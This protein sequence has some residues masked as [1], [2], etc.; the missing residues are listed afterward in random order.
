MSL[1]GNRDIDIE[2]VLKVEDISNIRLVN[3]YFKCICESDALWYRKI[4]DK[5]NLVKRD[6][7]SKKGDLIDIEITGERIR[8]MQKFLGL[9]NLKGLDNI[10]NKLPK[11]AIYL[12]Y[13][14]FDEHSENFEEIYNLKNMKLPKCVNREEVYYELLRS[15]FIKRYNILPSGKIQFEEFFGKKINRVVR[16]DFLEA[17][18]ILG[19]L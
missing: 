2:I 11:N 17:Y 19:I 15:Y 18:K 12:E 8:E 4:I 9:R 16:Q 10:L 5:I 13:Y 7:F 14:S 1:T 3:K 6:N